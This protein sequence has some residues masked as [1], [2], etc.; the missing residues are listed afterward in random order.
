MSPQAPR[1]RHPHASDAR[2]GRAST[3][4]GL[5]AA[6]A[7]C[8]AL[9]GCGGGGGSDDT[10]TAPIAADPLDAVPNS[11]LASSA[12]LVRYQQQLAAA[13][14]AEQHAPLDINGFT[15]PTSDTDAPVELL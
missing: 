3:P 13:P 15:L 8:L 6:L 10:S 12:S 5:A 11:A 4:A 2:S 7:L 9:G 1:P 14:N